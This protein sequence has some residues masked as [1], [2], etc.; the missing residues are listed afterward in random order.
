MPISDR[1]LENYGRIVAWGRAAKSA[2]ERY[3]KRYE[4][5]VR[6]G[7]EERGGTY[8]GTAVT[9]SLDDR[10]SGYVDPKWA[11]DTYGVDTLLTSGA[12]QVKAGPLTDVGEDVSGHEC[13]GTKVL[14]VS[15]KPAVSKT[16]KKSVAA[17]LKLYPTDP[18]E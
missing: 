15:A 11:I 18:S 9:A 8:N 10:A 4:K 14:H 6:K 12:I 17:M 13:K 2:F 5:D 3:L 7:V 1:T 16:F